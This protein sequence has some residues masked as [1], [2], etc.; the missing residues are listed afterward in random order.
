MICAFVAM[1][2]QVQQFH[3]DAWNF[4]SPQRRSR[5]FI[6]IAA[7]ALTPMSPPPENHSHPPGVKNRALG[8]A[9]NGLSLGERNLD[10]ITPFPY[11]T[12]GQATSDLPKNFDGRA[13]SIRYPDHQV[14]R[15]EPTDSLM[16]IACIPRYPQFSS[17]TTA[18]KQ[19]LIPQPLID[20]Y[21]SFFNNP[22]KTQAG[23]RA[24]QRNSADTLIPTVTT[25][26]IPSDAFIGNSLHWTED[27]C[28]TVLEVRRA[29]GFPDRDVIVGGPSIQWRIVGNS[30]PRT[31]ALALGISLREDGLLMRKADTI[32]HLKS[33]I[34]LNI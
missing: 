25:K 31:L 18:R 11:R 4:G 29:Q 9:A 24:W 34:T 13:T 3:L 16:R 5:L 19:N 7:P 23:T 20:S 26:I 32:V 10:I 6:S 1:G 2:Y 17:M 8:K 27:R 33:M 28:L 12:I 15:T 21:T 22:I 14:S 30:V